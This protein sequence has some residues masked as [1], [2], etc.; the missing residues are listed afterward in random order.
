MTRR[1]A[2]PALFLSLVLLTLNGCLF[3]S[4]NIPRRVYS[5]TIKQSTLKEL[6]D[7]INSDAAKIQ[8][9]K[10]TVDIATTVENRKK[11][12][13]TDY[14]E[15]RGYILVR[16]PSMLHMIGL[17][18][19]V[20]TRAFDMVS[21]GKTFKL[22]IP[23]KNKFITGPTTVETPSANQ[24]ENLRPDVFFDSLLLHEIHDNEIAVFEQSSEDV[25]DAKD[26]KKVVTIPTYVIDVIGKPEQDGGH[27]FLSRK[28]VFDSTD[29]SLHRQLIYDKQGRLATEAVYENFTVYNGIDFPS[30]VIINRPQEGYSFQ[31]AMVK[32]GVQ[33]NVL[34]KDDQFTLNQPSGAQVQ[35]L[36]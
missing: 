36:H 23:P 8:S 10:A 16:K 3:H 7:K 15:I 6:V 25:Q 19:V 35:T 30:L 26:K 29:L 9:L 34:L 14:T 20:R 13:A 21:D 12:T 33:F 32:G 4:R 2:L 1:P 22:S 11:S 31:V 24:L 27:Y 5:G 17:L 18:P 28:I